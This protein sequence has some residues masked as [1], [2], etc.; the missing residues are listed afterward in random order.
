MSRRSVTFLARLG[1]QIAFGLAFTYSTIL[2]IASAQWI[3]HEFY[4]VVVD[5]GIIDIRHE[6]DKLY[7]SGIMDKRR[8]CRFIEAVAYSKTKLLSLKYLDDPDPAGRR[9]RDTGLQEF[10]PWEIKPDTKYIK[11]TAR[12]QCHI[13]WD[14][15]T[16]VFEGQV[17]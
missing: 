13:F 9:S 17:S 1:M 10:G 12:H 14:S 5:V 7:V 3:E 11:I 16:D 8:D 6:H 4:P 2:A 15:T